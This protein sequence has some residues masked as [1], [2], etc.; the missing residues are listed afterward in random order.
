MPGVSRALDSL[1]SMTTWAN[2]ESHPAIPSYSSRSKDLERTVDSH[3]HSS[4]IP[5]AAGS[6][7]SSA[8]WKSLCSRLDSFHRPRCKLQYSRAVRRGCK[9]VCVCR[10]KIRRSPS[11]SRAFTCDRFF[12]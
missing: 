9:D 4:P 3:L 6:R 1:F 11:G 7:D 12:R 8:R 10:S 2:E 5:P